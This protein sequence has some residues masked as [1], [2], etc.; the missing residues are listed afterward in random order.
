MRHIALSL[1]LG[2]YEPNDASAVLENLYGDSRDQVVLLVSMLRSQGVDAYPALTRNLP[3]TFVEDVP[4]LRQFNQLIVALPTGDGYRFLD[5]RLDDA[6]YTHLHWGRGNMAFVVLD[7]GTGELVR[8]PEFDPEEN[9]ATKFL[10]ALLVDDGFANVRAS[11]ELRGYFD[12]Q[13]R[14]ALK[15]ATPSE[16]EKYFDQA[17]GALSQGA[18]STE[19]SHSD[20]S[21]LMEVVVVRQAIEAPDFAV[22]Q[23]DMIICRVPEYPYRFAT[24]DVVPSLAERELPFDNQCETEE[25]FEMKILVPKTLTIEHLPEPV[26]IETDY[27]DFELTCTWDPE[28]RAVYWRRTVTIKEQIVP[29][30]AYDEFKRAYDTITS[31]K[32]SLIL[33]TKVVHSLS[34]AQN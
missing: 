28:R 5:P 33:F 22:V 29:V 18:L 27:A 1:G 17:A 30:E 31:P 24:M 7:D 34:P 15:D 19:H 25:M 9:R 16:E 11:C 2:G 32:N 26:S 23:G 6:A 21:N 14:R 12:R 3:A 10:S 8:I 13:A 20:L 4:T